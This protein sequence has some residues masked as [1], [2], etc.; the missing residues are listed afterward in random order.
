MYVKLILTPEMG[1][2]RFLT[3]PNR[4]T[5]TE[6]GSVVNILKTR[7]VAFGSVNDF[8]VTVGSVDIF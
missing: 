5:V 8:S 6:T 3:E 1:S 4:P 2:V 7:S